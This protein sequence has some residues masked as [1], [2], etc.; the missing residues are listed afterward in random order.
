[1]SSSRDFE[2][3][4]VFDLDNDLDNLT[5]FDPAELDFFIYTA[6][7]YAMLEQYPDQNLR[8]RGEYDWYEAEQYDVV[9]LATAGNDTQAE[10]KIERR[11]AERDLSPV[12]E[13][14]RAQNYY[15]QRALVNKE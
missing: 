12:G 8:N 4:L 15:C 1:M 2:E 14:Y 11:L 9:V 5:V 7:E 13:I 3:E 6:Y 10:A